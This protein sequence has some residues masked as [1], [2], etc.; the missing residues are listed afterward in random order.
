MPNGTRLTLNA[1][2][3][4]IGISRT[5]LLNRL[6]RGIPRSEL[7]APGRGPNVDLREE[8]AAVRAVRE[9]GNA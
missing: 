4:V 6:T 9:D 3:R 2:A 8:R 1:A 5:G 7:F